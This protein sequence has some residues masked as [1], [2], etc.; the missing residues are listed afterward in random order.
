MM[1]MAAAAIGTKSI[2]LVTDRR[3][4][5]ANGHF[6]DDAIKQITV[7]TTDGQALLGYAGLGKT[8]SGTEPSQ[9]MS[10]VL[11]GRNLS[12]EHTLGVLADAAKTQLP[13][14]LDLLGSPH[15]VIAPAFVS[16][17]PRLYVIELIR[18]AGL[19]DYTFAFRRLVAN[20]EAPANSWITPNIVVTGSGRLDLPSD[21]D[22][23]GE[24]MKLITAHDAGEIPPGRVEHFLAALNYE[25]SSRESSV[26]PQCMISW[27]LLDKT[28]GLAYFTGTQRDC[29]APVIPS[30]AQG[31][32]M[33]ALIRVLLPHTKPILEAMQRGESKA[34][35]INAINSDLAKLPRY[36]DEKLN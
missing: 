14:H 26:G 19:A 4:T 8:A 17:E 12:M 15:A 18:E 34:P 25:V 32:D 1:T 35:D 9:W 2:W 5:Y 11:R 33:S 20:P 23:M 3:L 6:S 7:E 28:G 13:K 36:P 29:N 30:V 22:W 10:N 27:S 24:L 21:R 31:T 16:G